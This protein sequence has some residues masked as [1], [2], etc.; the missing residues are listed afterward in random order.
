MS[1]LYFLCLLYTA[2]ESSLRAPAPTK[3]IQHSHMITPVTAPWNSTAT[4]VEEGQSCWVIGQWQTERTITYPEDSP[5]KQALLSQQGHRSF[6]D[7]QHH[8]GNKSWGGIPTHITPVP[9]AKGDDDPN[10]DHG[11]RL[12]DAFSESHLLRA[13]ISDGPGSRCLTSKVLERKQ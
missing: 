8:T 5:G 11:S 3:S 12:Q 6:T 2:L 4:A 1:N 7:E 10:V 13:G 9:K